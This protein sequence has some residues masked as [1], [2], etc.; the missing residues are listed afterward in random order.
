MVKN[1]E[2]KIKTVEFI[3]DVKGTTQSVTL[4]SRL[5]DFTTCTNEELLKLSKSARED[6]SELFKVH[7]KFIKPLEM[8]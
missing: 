2:A 1:W 7:K 5:K 6:L 3:F 4:G 8:E